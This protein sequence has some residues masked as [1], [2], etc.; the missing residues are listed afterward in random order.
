MCR[1]LYTFLLILSCG[2]L[3]SQE[4]IKYTS[5]KIAIASFS[6]ETPVE[7]FYIPKTIETSLGELPSEVHYG[8]NE[9]DKILYMVNYV[10]YPEHSF[11]TD[12]LELI[13]TFLEASIHSHAESI[14]G[15]VVYTSVDETH[16]HSRIFRIRYNQ[17]KAVLKG[18]AILRNDNYYMLQIFSPTDMSMNDTHDHF[19]S[20]FRIKDSEKL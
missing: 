18:K 1:L 4:L 6:I 11:D 13:D 14:E 5:S 15:E 8:Y 9:D 7:L 3:H 20:S 19:L 12:S 16:E 17:G 2:L 10:Q